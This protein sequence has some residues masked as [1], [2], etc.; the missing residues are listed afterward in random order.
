MAYDPVLDREMFRPKSKGVEELRN[1]EESESVRARREQALA[2]IEAA[3][4]KFDPANYQTL[5]EQDRPG[6]F[7]PVAV[8]IPAQQQTADTAMRMQQMAA[9]GVRPVGMADGGSVDNYMDGPDTI[10]PT[11]SS[12]PTSVGRI[13]ALGSRIRGIGSLQA[14]SSNL[15]IKA[16]E[17]AASPS[18]LEDTRFGG[19]DLN[20]PTSW[21]DDQIRAAAEVEARR[22]AR[23]RTGGT[24][25]GRA[26]QLDIKTNADEIEKSLQA[27]RDMAIQSKR[28]SEGLLK[29]IEGAQKAKE[30]VRAIEAATPIPGLLEQS[31]E[32]QVTAAQQARASALA[33]AEQERRGIVDLGVPAPELPAAPSGFE[34]KAG[35]IDNLGVPVAE[36]AAAPSGLEALRAPGTVQGGRVPGTRDDFEGTVTPTPKAAKP[37]GIT[38]VGAAQEAGAAP[39]LPDMSQAGPTDMQQIKAERARAREENINLALI[40][41]GLGI[42]A[43]KSSNALANIGEGAQAGIGAFTEGEKTAQQQM[44]E[45]V[46][47]L[48][49]QQKMAQDKAYRESMLG[50]EGTKLGMEGERLGLAREAA[51]QGKLEFKQT[52]DFKKDEAAKTL[53]AAKATKDAS[54]IKAAADNI[55]SKRNTILS[56]IRSLTTS[57]ASMTNPEAFKAE[58]ENLKEDL[59]QA[60]AEWAEVQA[61]RGIK[62]PAPAEKPAASKTINYGDLPK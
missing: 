30:G 1:T 29:N 12:D 20:D 61:L 19:L 39:K 57:Q 42:M 45:A 49:E 13:Q 55:I 51:A 16:A 47:D 14:P 62:T 43:G 37:A 9:Q 23:D 11:I 21:T 15:G 8:N 44:R 59:R 40:R 26:L 53:E 27:E 48:R 22:V 25:L 24:R 54:Y 33:K 58:Y 7:R 34:T 10:Y 3:K 56:A 2:M 50:L 31:T 5:T 35:G 46:S 4:Q 38:A 6:V 41:A 32:E 60:D 52:L 17:P 18:G 36:P 28:T